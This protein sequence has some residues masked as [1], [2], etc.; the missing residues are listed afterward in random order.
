[1]RN[2]W[3]VVFAVAAVV[4]LGAG[5]V[6]AVSQYKARPLDRQNLGVITGTHTVRNTAFVVLSGWG[7]SDSMHVD[8]RSGIAATL[9]VTV[10]GAPVEF[11]LF[12][13]DV[14]HGWAIREM[15]PSSASFDPGTGTVS[16][17]FTFVAAVA[18]GNYTVN[19]SWR[20]PTGSQVSLV[21]GS[22]VVQ[23]GAA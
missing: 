4:V 3:L 8:A 15:R 19:V 9:S 13:E 7:P 16:A 18:P 10:T 2:R 20:S 5:G 17:S 12:L 14:D 21:G 6:A 23:Y 22:L 11:R 1:M